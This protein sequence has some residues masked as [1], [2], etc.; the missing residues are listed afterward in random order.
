MTDIS[1]LGLGCMGMNF[2]NEER[3]IETV[4]YALDHGI[5]MFNTGEF[6]G[7]GESEMVLREALK[8]VPR[9][10]YFLSV[11]FG[12][13]QQPGGHGM[14]GLD[15]DPFHVKAH[16]NY[17]LHR[18]G[19][20]YVD[21]YQP[22]R[23]D[24]TVPVEDLMKELSE[25]EQE[26]YIRSIGLTQLTADNLERAAKVHPVKMVEMDYSIADRAIES[27]GV[28]ETARKNNIE[29]LAFGVLCHGILSADSLF[30]QRAGLPPVMKE[31]MLGGLQKIADEKNT[32]VEKLV[33]AYVYAKNPDMSIII[34]TTRKEHLQDAI[35]A[36]S[37]E[38]A[39]DDIQAM[40]AAFPSDALKGMPMRNYVFH[41][42][43][44]IQK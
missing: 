38:L 25:C 24:E 9:D 33:Q 17:S 27:N 14:Y 11:K 42:G 18:L 12:V 40:E 16:L 4:H 30:W 3:S 39:P 35:D 10:R 2:S 26:G 29:V 19:V 43:R 6:Y 7:G 32:T 31:K 13:L 15:V 5:T 36:L 41:N 23:M 22:A 34:G 44:V 20:D 1:R 37:I 8:D 28:L 21:L